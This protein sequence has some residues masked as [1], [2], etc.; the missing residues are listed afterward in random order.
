MSTD[1]VKDIVDVG[2]DD[3]FSKVVNEYDLE[4][5]DISPDQA[6]ELDNIKEKLAELLC[7]F[8]HQNITTDNGEDDEEV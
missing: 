6:F 7:D 3:M 8:V 2:I 5:G 1:S 4:F